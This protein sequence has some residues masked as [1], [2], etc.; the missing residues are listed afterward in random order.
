MP[1]PLPGA[2][3]QARRPFGPKPRRVAQNLGGARRRAPPPGVFKRVGP[4]G[5]VMSDP[6]GHFRRE[7]RPEAMVPAHPGRGRPLSG[8]PLVSLGGG[9]SAAW[10]LGNH[11]LTSAM[12]VPATVSRMGLAPPLPPSR[13]RRGGRPAGGRG[14]AS[15]EGMGVPGPGRPCRAPVFFAFTALWNGLSGGRGDF[16]P[17]AWPL[18]NLAPRPS[19]FFRVAGRL[20]IAFFGFCLGPLLLR[21]LLWLF[22]LRP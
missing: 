17:S 8:H 4:V 15:R 3:G 14:R 1:S 2:L 9:F 10:R 20:G 16:P 19:D 22:A 7:I 12:G 21:V 5:R 18:P 11:F 6:W 13:G